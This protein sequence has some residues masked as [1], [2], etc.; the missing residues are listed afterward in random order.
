[1]IPI[2]EANA[3]SEFEYSRHLSVDIDVWFDRHRH[4]GRDY[5]VSVSDE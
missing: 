4:D 2:G 5:R 1:M 3:S